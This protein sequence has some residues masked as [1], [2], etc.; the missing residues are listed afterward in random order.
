MHKTNIIKICLCECRKEC[1]IIFIFF[2]NLK[3]KR[4]DF[5]KND[6]KAP[7][8]F[9][10]LLTLK[11]RGGVKRLKFKKS[12]SIRAEVAVKGFNSYT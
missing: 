6:L 8:E 11:K 2:R 5:E 10:C 9:L 3:F 12:V 4:V 7:P 1:L